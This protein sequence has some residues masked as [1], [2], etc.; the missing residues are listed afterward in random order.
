YVS[1]TAICL[2]CLLE[3]GRY[4]ELAELL[5]K[6]RMK[7]WAW[8]RLGAAAVLRQGRW[9][10]A[11]TFADS[12]RDAGHDKISIDLFCEKVLIHQ[13]LWVRPN[14]VFGLGAATGTQN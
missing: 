10:E 11:F 13:G 12:V 3:A 14:R 5:A 7:F 2:S 6:Q 8:Q 4:A 9:K 1:G